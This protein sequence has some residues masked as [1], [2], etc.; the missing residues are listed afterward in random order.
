[1]H[2]KVFNYTNSKICVESANRGYV[3]DPA[4]DG[5]PS[6][7]V[8]SFDEI[9]YINSKGE[10][11]RSGALRFEESQQEEIF[12]ALKYP[13]WRDT[14]ISEDDIDDIIFN[15]TIENQNRLISIKNAGTIERIRAKLVYYNNLEKDGVSHKI[16]NM[17]NERFDELR[18]GIYN[19]KIVVGEIKRINTADEIESVKE[20]NEALKKKIEEMETMMAEV[21]AKKAESES[22][23]SDAK[24]KVSK[25]KKQEDKVG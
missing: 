22:D 25:P 4:K 8:M 1:M 21:L 10:I 6:L 19:S 9:E 15:P 7:E 5:V 23:T 12:E 2:I 24:K 16:T 17:I 14:L 13:Q 18:R 3:F 11:F 20:Q